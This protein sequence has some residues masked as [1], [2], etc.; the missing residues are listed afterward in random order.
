MPLVERRLRHQ[1]GAR[2][3]EV[4]RFIEPHAALETPPGPETKVRRGAADTD[5]V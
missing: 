3:R 1:R 5:P 2:A 4:V